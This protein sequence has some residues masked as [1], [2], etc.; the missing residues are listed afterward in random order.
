M[1]K[2]CFPIEVSFEPSRVWKLS[3]RTES[4]DLGNLAEW[5]RRTNNFQSIVNQVTILFEQGK[6]CGK[7]KW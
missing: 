2:G 1:D 4:R 5:Q 7:A 3:I 6:L